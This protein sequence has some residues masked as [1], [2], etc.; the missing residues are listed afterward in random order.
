MD[1]LEAM[2]KGY[3]LAISAIRSGLRGLREGMSLA[4]ADRA[5]EFNALP[6]DFQQQMLDRVEGYNAAI[7]DM[8]TCLS[9]SKTAWNKHM[10]GME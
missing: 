7:D 4:Q 2:K 1:D 10:T 3:D 6:P 8:I 9:V 5:D